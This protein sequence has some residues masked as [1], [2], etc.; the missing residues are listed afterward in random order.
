MRSAFTASTISAG[1]W[2]GREERSSMPGQP[3][4]RQRSAHR[5]AVGQETRKRSA[6]RRMGQPSSTATRASFSRPTGSGRR[7]G[8]ARRPPGAWCGC[9]QTAPH[10]ARRSSSRHGPDGPRRVTNLRSQYIWS[11]P[12]DHVGPV[13]S[14]GGGRQGR[15]VGEWS[16]EPGPTP[17]PRQECVHSATQ[18]RRWRRWGPEPPHL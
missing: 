14:P 7:C 9:R 5:W 4:W 11:T 13:D 16:R 3:C 17:P 12:R 8:G 15:A 1:A 6:A 10:L 18:H 2:C